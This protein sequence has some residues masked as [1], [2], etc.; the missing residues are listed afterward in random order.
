MRS[1][2]K[3]QFEESIMKNLK[4][5]SDYYNEMLDKLQNI[6][7]NKIYYHEKCR[8]DARNKKKLQKSPVKTPWHI[9]RE[10][11]QTVFQ[12]I[13]TLIEE[14]VIK[15]GRCYFLSFLHRQYIDYFSELSN[16]MGHTLSSVISSQYLEEKIRVQFAGNIQI[17]QSGHKKV[18]APKG[19]TSID[20]SLFAH[21]KERDIL[22][23]AASILHKEIMNIEKIE[24]PR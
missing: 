20:E 19:I 14:N 5:N 23:A 8:T 2:N 18:I 4:I 9:S 12:E 24:T 16:D 13:C 11:H 3:H 10:Y 15:K 17:L 22:Q 7:S 6:T 1:C 21:L